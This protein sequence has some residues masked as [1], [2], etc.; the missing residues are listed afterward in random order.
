[1]IRVIPDCQKI[2]FVIK[3]ECLINVTS[4]ERSYLRYE[5]GGVPLKGSATKLVTKKAYTLDEMKSLNLWV[6]YYTRAA[7]LVDPQLHSQHL[8]STNFPHWGIVAYKDVNL[9]LDNKDIDEAIQDEP[10][11]KGEYIVST[12]EEV[13]TLTLKNVFVQTY[14]YV[15]HDVSK[16]ELPDGSYDMN[17]IIPF[18]LY[19]VDDMIACSL[20]IDKETPNETKY[21]V[22]LQPGLY[23][24]SRIQATSRME[25]E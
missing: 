10:K 15:L 17:K 7:A 25:I 3:D 11:V 24:F 4:S 13:R 2:A 8:R 6:V 16:E 21:F 14:R 1:M 12:K 20:M 5:Y 22:E 9:M 23:P 19:Q 18:N